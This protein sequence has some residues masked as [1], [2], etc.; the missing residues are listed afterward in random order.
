MADTYREEHARIPPLIF[1][2]DILARYAS[3]DVMSQA[4]T[5]RADG[6]LKGGVYTSFGSFLANKVTASEILLFDVY[7]LK[8]I[9]G[10]EL[11][12]V[13]QYLGSLGTTTATGIGMES[14]RDY[15]VDAEHAIQ[16]ISSICSTARFTGTRKVAGD[17][18]GSNSLASSRPNKVGKGEVVDDWSG[19][20]KE[21]Y[22][23]ELLHVKVAEG[24]LAVHRAQNLEKEFGKR[25]SGG[26]AA[27]NRESALV[28]GATSSLK[29][30]SWSDS[31]VYF[32]GKFNR[33]G[34]PAVWFDTAVTG[35]PVIG[36]PVIA[37]TVIDAPQS[38]KPST[39]IVS[40]KA[41]GGKDQTKPHTLH[42]ALQYFDQLPNA[43]HVRQPV[44]EAILGCSSA[45]VWRRV[46]DGRLPNPIK[47]SP[48]ISAWNVG[49]LRLSLSLIISGQ[50]AI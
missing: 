27:R 39:G 26:P 42:S 34:F 33:N 11:E 12:E 20:D 10:L 45:T 7:T 6:A 48:R 14:G 19:Q 5:A 13:I 44:V 30:R 21:H 17:G 8:L 49:Q 16:L 29:K 41:K 43:A 37:A 9:V 47:L 1:L 32:I 24:R 50:D 31:Y 3:C 35:W 38:E 4:E 23:W 28:A 2:S 18:L 40:R 15:C 25:L 46:K 36:K 22:S